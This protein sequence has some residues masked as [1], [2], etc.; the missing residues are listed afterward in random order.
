[1]KDLTD[2]VTLELSLPRRRGRPSTG[3]AMSPAERK[4]AQRKRDLLSR[5]A[6]EASTAGL[7]A[8]LS[9]YVSSGEAE[10]AAW[11]ADVLVKRAQ[12][13]AQADAVTVTEKTPSPAIGPDPVTVT[14][15]NI[16]H[17]PMPDAVAVT[18]NAGDDLDDWE[19]PALPAPAKRA[20]PA[21][22]YRH[23][24]TGETWSGRGMAPKC[25]Q[26]TIPATYWDDYSERCS[27]DAQHQLALEVRRAGNRVTIQA[28][29][30]QLKY[31][32]SDAAFY[33]EG[34]TDNTPHSV[35]RGAKRVVV[36]CDA[37]MT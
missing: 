26:L 31:L 8:M 19:E 13:N 25:V 18:E 15:N 5:P 14:E 20:R 7:L 22:K 21:P 29:D 1:M 32:K 24:A 33:A 10:L 12:A 36:L 4:R 30:V 27:V 11:V 2:T 9:R 35:I 6:R 23:A 34:N 3:K 16:V 17:W 37:A 28:N